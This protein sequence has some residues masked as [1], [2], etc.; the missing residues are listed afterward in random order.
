MCQ[1]EGRKIVWTLDL[2]IEMR[3]D[4]LNLERFNLE[5]TE[6]R[7][8]PTPNGPDPEWTEPRMY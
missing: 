6:P 5:W 7:M 4:R 8:D 1:A 2:A 3:M